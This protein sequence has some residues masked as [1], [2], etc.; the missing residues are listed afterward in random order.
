[1]VEMSREKTE[2]VVLMPTLRIQ[3]WETGAEL[4]GI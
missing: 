3:L 4:D 2:K 1:M